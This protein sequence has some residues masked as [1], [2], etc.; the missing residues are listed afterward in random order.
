[1]SLKE[2]LDKKRNELAINGK[3]SL[4]VR[5]KPGAKKEDWL[6]FIEISEHLKL[7]VK[8]SPERGKANKATIAFLAEYF[9]VRKGRVVIKQGYN[10][11][12]KLIQI[13]LR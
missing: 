13:N 10:N 5:V 6:D 9:G 7:A 8:A 12:N 4:K 2:Y 1:M 11:P 3:V